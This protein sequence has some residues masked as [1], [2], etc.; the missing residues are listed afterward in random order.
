MPQVPEPLVRGDQAFHVASTR[1]VRRQRPTRQH[2]FQ[3]VQKLLGDL[4]VALV[5]GVMECDQD[6]V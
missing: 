6:L 5:A 4:E 2:H 1:A 3:D